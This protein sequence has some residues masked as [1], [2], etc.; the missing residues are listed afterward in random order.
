MRIANQEEVNVKE[1][2]DDDLDD[3][4]KQA[5][6]VSKQFKKWGNTPAA[7]L[8]SKRRLPSFI[9]DPSITTFDLKKLR[10]DRD[11]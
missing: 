3:Y 7:P 1:I 4:K 9:S 8:Q 10:I 11:F 5:K 6:R 2:D